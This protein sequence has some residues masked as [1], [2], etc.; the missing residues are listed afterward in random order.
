M[1]PI[2]EENLRTGAAFARLVSLDAPL[3]TPEEVRAFAAD[4][5][6]PEHEAFLLLLAAG[7]FWAGRPLL[8]RA[9]PLF[10]RVLLAVFRGAAR[11]PAPVDGERLLPLTGDVF[12]FSVFFAGI[13]CLLALSYYCIIPLFF[14]FFQAFFGYV[15]RLGRKT[16]PGGFRGAAFGRPQ[17]KGASSFLDC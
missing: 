8:L 4:C 16:P 12:R 7:L 11:L 17:G 2:A 1:N 9:G 3:Y 15:S 14:P 5:G 10:L 13:T 6:L